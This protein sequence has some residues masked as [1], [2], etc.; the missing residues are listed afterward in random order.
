MSIMNIPIRDNIKYVLE[1]IF[2]HNK[3]PHTCSKLI[4]IKLLLKLATERTHIFQYQ[5]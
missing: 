3:L 5:F 4:L 1:E 2:S